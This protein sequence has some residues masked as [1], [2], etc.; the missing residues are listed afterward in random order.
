MEAGSI[1]LKFIPI[2]EYEP[3]DGHLFLGEAWHTE[4]ES[5]FAAFAVAASSSDPQ[6]VNP[7][8]WRHYK[9]QYY[10]VEGEGRVMGTVGRAGTF[11]GQLHTLYVPKYHHS[12]CGQMIRPTFGSAGFLTPV[13]L[14]RGQVERFT[15]LGTVV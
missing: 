4:L 10:L 12:G 15:W 7:G 3:Y 1:R 2:D 6:H 14:S 8:W 5:S 9:G 13:A 11:N